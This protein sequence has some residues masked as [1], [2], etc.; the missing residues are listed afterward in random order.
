MYVYN[1]IKIKEQTKF[2]DK[3]EYNIDDLS[4]LTKSVM[5]DILNVKQRKIS[6]FKVKNELNTEKN[7]EELNEK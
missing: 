5:N 1:S 6:N 4:T 7:E 2:V 3:K